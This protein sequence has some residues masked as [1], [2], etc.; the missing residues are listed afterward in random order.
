LRDVELSY[1]VWDIVQPAEEQR[2]EAQAWLQQ[3]QAATGSIAGGSE[4]D[5]GSS[6]AGMPGL[7]CLGLKGAP[8][9]GVAAARHAAAAAALT[10]EDS[11]DDQQSVHSED[12]A[13]YLPD[14]EPDTDINLEED[15]F[16]DFDPAAAA[17]EEF[18]PADD[19]AQVI[20]EDI[21]QLQPGHDGSKRR[22]RVNKR[23]YK[24]DE[25]CSMLELKRILLNVLMCKARHP[26]CDTDVLLMVYA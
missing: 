4:L 9:A 23:M 16:E 8:L 13:P 17:F 3:L 20:D 22:R 18:D 24:I 11:D 10:W 21:L 15:E 2:A 7:C 1:P 14:Y 6:C 25:D 19:Q 5:A 26:R 12:S